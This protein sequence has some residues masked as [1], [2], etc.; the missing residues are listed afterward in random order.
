MAS[1]YIPMSLSY[2]SNLAHVP[3][4]QG[5]YAFVFN[6]LV[7]ALLG[8]C[9]Q[10]VVG[11]EAPGSLLVGGVVVDNIRRGR[12]RDDEAFLHA[13]I[14]G[15]VTSVAG[16]I[17]LIAGFARL[18]FLDNVLSR[19][20]L[21]GFIS[22]IGIVIIIDQLIPE[23]GLSTLAKHDNAAQHGSSVVKLVFL[24]SNIKKAHALTSAL[25]LGCFAITMVC[26]EVKKRLQPRYPKVA[27]IPDRFLIVVSATFLAWKL[28]WDN[29][30]LEILGD[31]KSHG[32]GIFPVHFPF[33]F[34]HIKDLESALSTSF[35]ISL[36]GFFESSV[37]AKS[38]GTGPADGIQNIALS[39]NR[40][41]VGL[42]TANVIG[43]I[44]MGIPAFGGYGRSK[45]NAS[46]GGK[47]PMSSVFLSLITLLCVLF[48]LPAF[49]YIPVS[50]FVSGGNR[51]ILII[52]ERRL[53][54]DDLR[55]CVF[56]GRRGPT[57]PQILLEDTGMVRALLGVL[58]LSRH[59][60]LF[61]T[62][63]NSLWHWIFATES[64]QTQ[65]ATSNTDSGARPGYH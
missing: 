41:L 21:R 34:S 17:L 52:L 59:S 18:G 29:Q 60:V 6:P 4:V 9:P 5:M 22:A 16:A 19:P 51:Q 38:L 37:A 2:A 43:G 48:L 40:E 45:V 10:M 36:L 7:Y 12:T 58:S 35:L 57:R 64:H 44:F 13:Q 15:V 30:G 1:F 49:Y 32:V 46:T 47:T 39:P 65:H 56:F 25:S 14:A 26:R 54:G 62:T 11:P 33:D 55:R 31:V 53:V 61:F 42:G 20:F 28:N 8:T 3:P 24:I 50:T 23:L 27:Y 63:R